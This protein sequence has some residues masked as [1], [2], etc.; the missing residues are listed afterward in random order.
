MGE[1]IK[2]IL[3]AAGAL[4]IASTV[5][6]YA[7]PV[8]YVLGDHPDGDLRCANDPDGNQCFDYGLRVDDIDELFTFQVGSTILTYDSVAL[9]ASVSGT[10]HVSRQARQ[11]ARIQL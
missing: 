10:I 3:G 7:V 1:L 5:S 2:K 9:T 4:V 8:Q 6:S 11:A